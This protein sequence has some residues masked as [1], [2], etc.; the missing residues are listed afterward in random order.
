MCVSVPFTWELKRARDICLAHPNERVIVGGPA[1]RLMPSY[2]DN[3]SSVEVEVITPDNPLRRANPDASRTTFGCPNSCKFCG[4]RTIEGEY[5]ELS[6]FEVAPI[7]C[8]SNFLACSDRHFNRVIDALKNA[9]FKEVDFNQAL[10][11]KS[12]TAKRAARLAEINITPRFAWDRHEEEAEVFDALRLME[13]VGVPKSRF[14]AVLCLVGMDETE[15]EA[16][17]RM[18]TLRRNGYL[19]FAMRYQPLDTLV[20]NSY[21]PPQWTPR[22]LQQFCRY[23]NRQSW[24]GGITFEEYIGGEK[25]KYQ[26][27]LF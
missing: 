25:P 20:R 3:V 8:D 24:F 18:E 6:D 27:P 13:R 5:R 15:E 26:Y 9:D 11:A 19:G 10:E 16:T 23:W 2:F 7:L 17:Y 1:V 4:V 22:R 12:L 21:C 14:K